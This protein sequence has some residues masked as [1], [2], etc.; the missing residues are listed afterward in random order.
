MTKQTSPLTKSILTGEGI[1][2]YVVNVALAIAASIPDTITW[3]HAGIFITILTVL[4]LVSRTALKVKALQAGI[5]YPV[6]DINPVSPDEIGKD[7]H[8]VLDPVG[9][10]RRP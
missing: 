8:D 1:L 7:I 2:V 6:P 4:H 9:G 3:T 10:P 5:G